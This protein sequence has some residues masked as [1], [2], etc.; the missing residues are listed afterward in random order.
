MFIFNFNILI[1]SSLF[2]WALSLPLLASEDVI[3][4]FSEDSPDIHTPTPIIL[5]P[6]D[7]AKWDFQFTQGKEALESGR[8][9]QAL[10]IFGELLSQDPGDHEA[11][12]MMALTLRKRHQYLK[13]LRIYY[14]LSAKKGELGK[15]V[16]SRNLDDSWPDIVALYG[17]DLFPK[18]EEVQY[19]YDIADTFY[20]YGKFLDKTSPQTQKQTFAWAEKYLELCER[21]EFRPATV[22]YL[23]G[24]LSRAQDKEVSA[25]HHFYRAFQ[26]SQ[27]DPEL[28]PK[29]E[30]DL[31]L[32]A[33]HKFTLEG[34]PEIAAHFYRDLEFNEQAFHESRFLAQY[35]AKD[36]A[37]AGPNFSISAGMEKIKH[38]A[39]R[40]NFSEFFSALWS[41]FR[42]RALPNLA[43]EG[44]FYK[45]A[46]LSSAVQKLQ[47]S[48]C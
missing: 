17:K 10:H 29:A 12:E 23:R 35:T 45:P 4:D 40:T 21:F 1:L 16:L 13:A 19:L 37:K 15:L 11:W 24:L 9:R 31:E 18:K 27:K 44:I 7:L 41:F 3:R 47:H 33:G 46:T 39:T 30:S 25:G 6:K 5:E 26:S 8:T 28:S 14:F 32:L 38:S 43:G 42:D 20:E 36:L 2:I 22:E 34:R 48:Q